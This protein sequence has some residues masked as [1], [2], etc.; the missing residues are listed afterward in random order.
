MDGGTRQRCLDLVVL[1]CMHSQPGLTGAARTLETTARERAPTR[2]E[3]PGRARKSQKEPREAR[4]SQEAPGRARKSHVL[5][6]LGGTRRS[7][8]R[9]ASSMLHRRSQTASP[10]GTA[11]AALLL[12]MSPPSPQWLLS[13]PPSRPLARRPVQCSG[14]TSPSSP[15]TSW[16]GPASRPSMQPISR[17]P[18]QSA[19]G[20]GRPKPGPDGVSRPR[21]GR[22]G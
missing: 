3:E 18:R 11:S 6:P 12:P 15:A 4:K 7:T 10:R 9:R 14:R 22:T 8:A 5:C 1:A 17:A 16:T 20:V 2:D 21:Q 13:T 19:Y